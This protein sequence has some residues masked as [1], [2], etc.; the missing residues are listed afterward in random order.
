M[1]GYK[2]AEEGTFIAD[3]SWDRFARKVG[4]HAEGEF[5][6]A[7]V[8]SY[9][10]WVVE[11][12]VAL[13]K[14]ADPEN[15]AHVVLRVDVRALVPLPANVCSCLRERCATRVE[16]EEFIEQHRDF[17]PLAETVCMMSVPRGITLREAVAF[18]DR[19]LASDAPVIP[20]LVAEAMLLVGGRRWPDEESL[21]N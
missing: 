6:T 5:L 4:E 13:H 2:Q 20:T 16:A 9:I 1:D 3:E 14:L 8:D 21:K 10:G 15:P 17:P 11:Q 7:G 12:E 18:I 19:T